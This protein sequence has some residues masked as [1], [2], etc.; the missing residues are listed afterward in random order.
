MMV[1]MDTTIG[2]ALLALALLN[3]AVCSFRWGAG[4]KHQVMSSLILTALA[5]SILL[6]EGSGGRTA[7][8]WTGFGLIVVAFMT[9]PG[10]RLRRMRLE[11]GLMT[12]AIAVMW[13][14]TLV[15][16]PYAVTIGGLALMAALLLAAFGVMIVRARREES[17]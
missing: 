9:T 2:S 10:A 15:E 17:L 1:Q 5:L 12:A 8:R 11:L 6:P 3:L 14:L 4:G 16:V 7:A 13:A